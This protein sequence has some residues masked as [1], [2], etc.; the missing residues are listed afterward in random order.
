MAVK[1]DRPS[2]PVPPLISSYGTPK[3]VQGAHIPFGKDE[4]KRR[5]RT[6]FYSAVFR[7][8]EAQSKFDEVNYR[9]SQKKPSDNHDSYRAV[10]G[11]A[12]RALL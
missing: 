8:G 9:T 10:M 5:E 11:L 2:S 12:Y 7:L 3:T 1:R 4:K 6:I